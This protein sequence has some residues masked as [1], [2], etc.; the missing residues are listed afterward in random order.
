MSPSRS[1]RARRATCSPESA[2]GVTHHLALSI[3]GA[4][5]APEGYYAG[6]LTQERDRSGRGAVDDPAGDAVPRVRR[7]HVRHR[8]G[9]AAC[10]PR[11]ARRHAADR[12]SARSPSILVTLAEAGP[13]AGSATRDPAKG[14]PALRPRDRQQLREGWTPSRRPLAAAP[15]RPGRP[16]DPG[17]PRRELDRA[18]R[19]SPSREG[20]WA[21]PQR[22]LV[23]KDY[24]ASAS[25][26]GATGR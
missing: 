15:P 21:A 4:D 9:R 12:R 3:V 25:H 10:T 22:E 8:E 23:T 14:S 13:G 5:A 7:A 26:G 18:R 17:P 2:A 20:P 6:K 11:R 24:P 19:S 16:G 1:S